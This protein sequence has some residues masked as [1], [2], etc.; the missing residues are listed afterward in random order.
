LQRPGKRDPRFYFTSRNH[1]G[2]V[3]VKILG[4]PVPVAKNSG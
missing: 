4:I 2:A 3:N 1:L